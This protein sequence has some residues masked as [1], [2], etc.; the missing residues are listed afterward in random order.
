M[1]RAG[2]YFAIAVGL[3]IAASAIYNWKK[4]KWFVIPEA[5]AAIQSKL[6]DPESAQFRNERISSTGVLC[7]EVNAKN[8][9]GGYVGFRKFFSHSS[10]N[11]IEGTGS[12]DEPTHEEFIERLGREIEMMKNYNAA[13][14]AHPAREK[15]TEQ[16]LAKMFNDKWKE[17]CE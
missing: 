1:N 12:L 5:R 2:V 16:A 10:A 7:G 6:R 4:E 8:G 15:I 3:G 9:M 13:G 17:H 14:V 11:Y